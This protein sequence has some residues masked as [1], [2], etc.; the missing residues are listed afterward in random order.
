VAPPEHLTLTRNKN[1]PKQ[2]IIDLSSEDPDETTLQHAD[3]TPSPVH[4]KR[5]TK[6]QQKGK[7]PQPH[8]KKK[9]NGRKWN[10]ST[11]EWVVET[12]SKQTVFLDLHLFWKELQ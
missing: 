11:L 3:L 5:A 1:K 10:R 12:P 8:G 6:R 9:S 7:P 2:R 4:L